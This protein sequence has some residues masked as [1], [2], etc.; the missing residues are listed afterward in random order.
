MHPAVTPQ[1]NILSK[2][3]LHYFKIFQKLCL[4]FQPTPNAAAFTV[5]PK[6][7]ELWVLCISLHLDDTVS[8]LRQ[9]YAQKNCC[10]LYCYMFGWATDHTFSDNFL[11]IHETV[12]DQLPK[13]ALR[14]PA[15]LPPR[16]LKKQPHKIGYTFS[17]CYN[18]TL[19]EWK[20]ILDYTGSSQWKTASH[21]CL[22]CTAEK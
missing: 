11:Q 21:K 1:S 17:L 20:I 14:I 10:C 15:S 16:M 9:A 8:M 13:P 18:K 19:P 2:K 3:I 4:T 6:K 5:T 22:K 12:T 7:R